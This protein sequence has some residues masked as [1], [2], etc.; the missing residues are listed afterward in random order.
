VLLLLVLAQLSLPSPSRSGHLRLEV[1]PG[2]RT[3]V[4]SMPR[5]SRSLQ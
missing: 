2:S 1:A 4:Q 3:P 5:A